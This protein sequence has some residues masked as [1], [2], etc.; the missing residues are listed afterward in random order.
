VGVFGVGDVD[1]AGLT[2]V[3]AATNVALTVLTL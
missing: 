3:L 2:G 1:A